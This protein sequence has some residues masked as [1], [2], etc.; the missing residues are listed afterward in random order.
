MQ[1]GWSLTRLRVVVYAAAL[2]AG[3]LA[4]WQSANY[5][6]P[7]T[8]W[9]W[10]GVWQSTFGI[11]ST[12]GIVVVTWLAIVISGL[13]A[14]LRLWASAHSRP[15]LQALGSLLLAAAV[16]VLLPP[17]GALIALPVLLAFEVAGAA[18]TR[19]ATPGHTQWTAAWLQE[20][21]ALGIFVSF[22]ALSWQYNAQLLVRAL[23]IACGLGLV[24]RAALPTSATQNQKPAA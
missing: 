4:P 13:G 11:S 9:V 21:A 17:V 1:S 23:L 14:A 7:H 18:S 15:R 12:S 20:V 6:D 22:A 10:L 16:C 2:A 3:Y 8:L 5:A 19:P 24:A